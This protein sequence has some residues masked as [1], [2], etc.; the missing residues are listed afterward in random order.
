MPEVWLL[1][2]KDRLLGVYASENVVED[3]ADIRRARIR[4]ALGRHGVAIHTE[5]RDVVQ[6]PVKDAVERGAVRRKVADAV[7]DWELL[8]EDHALLP[9][10]DASW[11]PFL[12]V[13]F[14]GRLW[15]PAFQFQTQGVPWPGFRETLRVL[16]DAG[17]SECHIFLW[18]TTAEMGADPPAAYLADDPDR[19]LVAARARAEHV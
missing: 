16:R 9:V 12:M 14:E 19:V 2:E 11:A 5:R 6:Y 18:F 15:F 13:P 3:Q 1:W 10:Q 17:L 7:Q 4:A 8:A